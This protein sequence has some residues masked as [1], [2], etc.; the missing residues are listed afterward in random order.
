MRLKTTLPILMILFSIA[1]FGQNYNT[2][3]LHRW[4]D[5]RCMATAVEG[6]LGYIGR[7]AIFQVVDFSDLEH[8]SE[9]GSIIL[10]APMSDIALLGNHAFVANFSGGLRVID[11]EDPEHPLEIN[12]YHEGIDI[13]SVDIYENYAF[14]GYYG[15]GLEIVDISDPL[16]LVQVYYSETFGSNGVV[17]QDQ[18]AFSVGSY[19]RVLDLSD[20]TNP[21]ERGWYDVP[22]LTHGLAVS[23]DYAYVA[24]YGFGLHV[25][26]ISNLDSLFLVGSAQNSFR[27][28]QVQVQGN[29]AYMAEKSDGFSIFDIS[30]PL[31]PVLSSNINTPGTAWSLVVQDSLMYLADGEDGVGVF[32]VTSASA[33]SEVVRFETGSSAKDISIQGEQIFVASSFDGITILNSSDATELPVIGSLDYAGN[34]VGL[35][36]TGDYA[37]LADNDSGL[38]IFNISDPQTPLQLEQ[39]PA[40][41]TLSDV[42]IHENYAYLANS[43]QGLRIVD[44]SDPQ[45]AFEVSL[46]LTDQTVFSVCVNNGYAYAACYNGFSILDISDPTAPISLGPFDNINYRI[47]DLDVVGDYA[48][49]AAYSSGLVIINIADPEH[50]FET[51]SYANN[52]YFSRAYG[53]S[54][55]HRYAYIGDYWNGL[56]IIDVSDPYN[57]FESGEFN[58]GGLGKKVLSID[59]LAY[60]AD[61]QDGV[62]VIRNDVAREFIQLDTSDALQGDTLSIGV[63][64]G[65]FS[66]STFNA[67]TLSIKGFQS[68]LEYLGTPTLNTMFGINDW[69]ISSAA[70]DTVLTISASGSTPLAGE[71]TLFELR[72][73][74]PDTLAPQSILLAI[75]DIRFD[76]SELD[77][78]VF[79]GK[80]NVSS[81]L[82]PGDVNLDGQVQAD[83][84]MLILSHLAGL[85]TLTQPQMTNADVNLDDL[86]SA[87]DASVIFHY[88][89]ALIDTLPI[90]DSDQA[91][92]ASGDITLAD[93]SVEPGVEV[94]FPLLISNS[95]NILSFE[96]TFLF[97]PEIVS[98]TDASISWSAALI[99]FSIEMGTETGS[100]RFA[101]ASTQA[102]TGDSIL[103]TFHL[104]VSEN[105]EV[106]QS[107]QLILENVRLNGNIEMSSLSAT[108]NG[109]VRVAGC[110]SIPTQFVLKQN[111]PNP[112]NPTTTIQYELPESSKVQLTIYNINGGLVWSRDIDSQDPGRYEIMWAGTDQNG[113]Q[114]STGVYLL[115]LQAEH[116]SQTI[117]MVYL[118]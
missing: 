44:I 74:V 11:I 112:F 90:D 106:D 2:T 76:D 37:Y 32:D 8:P 50:P 105:F 93:L 42:T 70:L 92:Q 33:P 51:G 57:P 118:R 59:N 104:L 3:L 69:Q 14:L 60:L 78:D 22:N 101:G 58:T 82:Q 21:L 63:H 67:L 36:V 20:I 111:Y 107:T 52:D 49:L 54:V 94:D 16:N 77:I 81:V 26:D 95:G 53:V 73:A 34:A 75:E 61:G 15:P 41:G 114:I 43:D 71:G 110:P 113:L 30:D 83:D 29:F 45:N 65:L 18:H 40:F 116:F 12:I 23:G 117:K 98:L 13:S 109:V 68:S 17:F 9:L 25:L 89:T 84:G 1:G 27:A 6:D 62:Y 39:Y 19:I 35:D 80:V 96:G 64:S 103:A 97:D 85:V 66:T 102:A 7:G 31:N 91:Y 10:P 4:A 87:W 100:L 88:A 48:Y 5:G 24:I 47:Y 86:V 99:D 28:W 115:K 55:S 72:F 38:V 79:S 46:A 108:L 56:R